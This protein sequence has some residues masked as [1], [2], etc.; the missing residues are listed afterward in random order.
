MKIIC[1]RFHVKTPFTFADMPTW[2]MWKVYLQ[3]F[4]TIKYVKN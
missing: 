2:D 3:T 1:R 4:R